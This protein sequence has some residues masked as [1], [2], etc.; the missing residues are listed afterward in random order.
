MSASEGLHMRWI[1]KIIVGGLISWGWR[2]RH[3]ISRRAQE[4]TG[5]SGRGSGQR[6]A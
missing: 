2:N 5:R 1:R 3:T 4:M 6:R